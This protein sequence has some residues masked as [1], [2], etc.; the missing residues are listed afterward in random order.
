MQQ[1]KQGMS[2]TMR[3]VYTTYKLANLPECPVLEEMMLFVIP[4]ST[5]MKA[6]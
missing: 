4:G 5:D 3:G 1:R 6:R 2:H